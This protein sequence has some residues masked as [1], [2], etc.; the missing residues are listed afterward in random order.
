MPAHIR[1]P[2][3]A[4]HPATTIGAVHLT[5]ADLDRALRFYQEALG[6]QVRQRAG[7]TARLGTGGPDDLLVLSERPGARPTRRTT[8][9]YHFAVLVPSRLELARSLRQLAQTRTPLQ[10]FS[11]H[12]VSEAIYLADPDGNGIEIYRDRPREEWPRKNGRIQMATDPLDLDGILAELERETEPWSGL[13][14]ET[15][16]GHIHLHVAD[17]GTAQAF[18]HGV[19]GFDLI[20]RLA[21][22]ADF[23]SAGGYHHHIGYNTWAGVGAP[24]PPP[25]AAGLRYFVIR[26]PNDAELARV[27]DRV[28]KAGLRLEEIEAGLLTRDPSQNG[29]VL[30]T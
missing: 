9:L 26:L 4:I 2:D 16:I 18:Y 29:V 30:A 14:P 23:V 12:L 19:L 7:D 8:G 10:G 3:T 20:Q 11:D 21:G 17:L 27:A 13:H 1:Q 24:P 28:R 15:T 25:D 6:F 22:S 5:V